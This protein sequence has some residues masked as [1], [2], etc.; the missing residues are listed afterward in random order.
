MTLAITT[1][2]WVTKRMNC[3]V[4]LVELMK[5]LVDIAS[6]LGKMTRKPFSHQME[7]ET[8]LLGLIHTDVCGLRHVSRQASGRVIE[9]KGIQD[10]D[11]SPSENNSK[12]IVEDEVY[13]SPHEDV[14]LVFRSVRT[15]QT[16][17][18]LCLNVEFK[19]HSL[20]DLNEP[21]SYKAALLY[22]KSNEWLD[23]MNAKMQS[24]K[25]NQV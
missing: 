25:D 13:E 18:S 6:T 10:E 19:D 12:N 1:K 15:Y 3:H 2:R 23:A 4:Y 8:D 7:K 14:A 5:K 16:P 21:T 17:E 9:L 24:M 11:T 20:R 22:P